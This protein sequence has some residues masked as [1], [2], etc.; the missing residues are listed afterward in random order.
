MI[1]FIFLF[2]LLVL[3]LQ[4]K[5]T[6]NAPDYITADHRPDK[7]L[8]EPKELFHLE[9]TLQNK[10]RQLIPFLRVEENFA[11]AMTPQLSTATQTARRS[12]HVEFT[13]WIRPRQAAV[14]KIPLT[15][16]KRGRYVLQQFQL[17]SGDFLG[18]KEQV[19]SCGTFHEVVAVPEE[20]P[21]TA[22]SDLFGGFLGD[23]SVNRFI[24]E[25][26][27]LTL[28]YREYTGREPMKII[29]WTQSARSNRLMVK[30]YDYTAEPSVSV[31]LNTDC[32]GPAVPELLETCFSIARSVCSMLENQKLKYSFSSN[33][34]PAGDLSGSRSLTE[35]L[36]QQHFYGIL[37]YLGQ[38]TYD[39]NM[40][41]EQL[42][43]K[44]A[45]RNTS[46]GCIL[47]TPGNKTEPARPLNRL[48]EATG[49]TLLVIRAS[50]VIS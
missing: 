34:I 10:S 11:D 41:I 14:Y 5:L 13:A 18:L 26:P 48:R 47:I 32:G 46:A 44:E 7:K 43:E 21:S 22:L 35:G 6:E 24:M 4:K 12:H 20:F 1:L 17:Y 50:E 38:A 8:V 16:S 2:I 45:A 19:R 40:N 42:L 36:G 39:Y 23:V 31:V 3:L 49:G 27:V 30:K 37:E 28:G 29:S 33:C 15:I 25:D 9:V